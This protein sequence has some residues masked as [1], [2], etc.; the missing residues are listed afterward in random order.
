MQSNVYKML[1]R[2]GFMQFTVILI[3]GIKDIFVT[4]VTKAKPL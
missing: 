4:F 1:N 3:F 2:V